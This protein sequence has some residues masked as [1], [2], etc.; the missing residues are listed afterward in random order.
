[1]FKAFLLL[2]QVSSESSLSKTGIPE[3]WNSCIIYETCYAFLNCQ[4]PILLAEMLIN[5]T[6]AVKELKAR[7]QVPSYLC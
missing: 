4:S 7:K 1:M 5:E 2:E 6:V 3:T